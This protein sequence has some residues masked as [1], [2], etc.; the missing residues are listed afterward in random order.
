MYYKFRRVVEDENNKTLA[1][2]RQMKVEV[3]C[4]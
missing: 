1:M 2:A 4:G 3:Y